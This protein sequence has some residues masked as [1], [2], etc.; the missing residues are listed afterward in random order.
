MIGREK[1]G[2][3]SGQAKPFRGPITAVDAANAMRAARLNAVDLLETAELLFDLK[4]FPH[5]LAFAILAIEEAGKIGL[6]QRLLLGASTPERCWKDYRL[7]RPKSGVL[8]PAIQAR[9]RV[10]FP[11]IPPEEA[12]EIAQLGPTPD[13]LEE[14]KQLAIYSDCLEIE[15]QLVSHLPRLAEWRQQASERLAEARAIVSCLRDRSPQELEVWIRHAEEAKRNGRP[16]RSIFAPATAEL[17]KRGFVQPGAFD[18]VLADLRADD[19]P[20]ENSTGNTD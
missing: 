7:H 2:P 12:R 6:L 18:S 5:A 4:R 17:I 10:N 14:A 11:E 9:V 3:D 20:A 13:E 15:G 19:V 16:V 1:F 8:N